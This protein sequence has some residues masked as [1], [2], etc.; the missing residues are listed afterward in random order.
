MIDNFTDVEKALERLAVP[1]DITEF[2][3]TYSLSPNQ[4]SIERIKHR[5]MQM[6]QTDL[7]KPKRNPLKL[8]RA[9]A[10]AVAAILLLILG[11]GPNNVA[12]AVN[13]LLLYIPG[14]GIHS[15]Q[16]VNLVAPNPVRAEKDGVK[17]D[18]NGVLADSKGTSLMAY[19]EGLIPDI[20]SS[21]LVDLSGTRYPYQGGMMST[22]GNFQN[23]WAWYKVLPANVKEA[24]LVIPS[25]SN[26]TI[27]IPLTTTTGL[28]T[29]QNFGPSLTINN[30]TVS[31]QSLS[32]PDETKVT[33]LVQSLR[34]GV[35]QSIKD[36]L[37]VA[38][39]GKTYPL[40]NQAAGYVGNDLM[41]YS[42]SPNIGDRLKVTIP[43]LNLL[44]DVHASTTIP[45]PDKN[46]LLTLNQSF[47][48]GTWNLK[49]T[50]AEVISQNNEDWLRIYV[51]PDFVDGAIINNLISQLSV[52]GKPVDASMSQFD[53]ST[54]G[55]KWFQIPYPT[56][57]KSIKI[58]VEN[59]NILVNGPW[60][61]EIPVKP[62]FN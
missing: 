18:I 57:Q 26:W 20:K 52:N 6:V 43:S 32:F 21:Y 45:V 19:V 27:N 11:I 36:P 14:F 34:G 35:V 55:I 13:R 25:L 16:N 9:A 49:L 8:W 62:G 56:G 46:S 40:N 22:A 7:H 15:T 12:A 39:D 31:A 58:T 47:I 44:L 38:A 48:L 29:A 10:V 42:T 59:I 28:G 4:E 50:K 1:D 17:I 60:K 54:G 5:T 37:V 24:A 53:E 30:V 3:K 41:Y 51:A 61:L 23:Y 2:T 33:F